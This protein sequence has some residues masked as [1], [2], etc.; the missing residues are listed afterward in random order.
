MEASVEKITS[1]Q[2]TKKMRINCFTRAHVG[3]DEQLWKK[4]LWINEIKVNRIG[5]NGKIFVHILKVNAYINPRCPRK[6]CGIAIVWSA[7]SGYGMN[8]LD[9]YSYLNT[10]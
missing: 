9:H 5:P 1:I 6:H 3:R 7:L 2:K 4:V 10:Q 8:P